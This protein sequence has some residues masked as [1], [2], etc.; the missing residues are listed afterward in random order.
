MISL[1]ALPCPIAVLLSSYMSSSA[2]LKRR[3]R[4]ENFM[5]NSFLFPRVN[6]TVARHV[7]QL[8]YGYIAFVLLCL[9]IIHSLTFCFEFLSV[10]QAAAS[11]SS[12]WRTILSS[13][14]VRWSGSRRLMMSPSTRTSILMWRTFTKLSANSITIIPI[15]GLM[16][17]ECQDPSCRLGR[18]SF[19]AATRPTVLLCACA[20][21]FLP[22]IAE[23]SVQKA[24]PATTIQLGQQM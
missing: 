22:V 18:R 17:P 6:Y 12:F 9:H 19:C 2:R 16:A 14:T 7:S 21:T 23:C 3:L 15:V 4:D 13:A 11:P 1:I 8:L 20:V 5:T 10:F 24:A